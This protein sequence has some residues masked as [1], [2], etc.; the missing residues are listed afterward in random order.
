MMR[1]RSE[2]CAAMKCAYSLLFAIALL[3]ATVGMVFAGSNYAT[4]NP[5]GAG[6]ST[7]KSGLVIKPQSVMLAEQLLAPIKNGVSLPRDLGSADPELNEAIRSYQNGQGS[8]SPMT[9]QKVEAD[10]DCHELPYSKSLLHDFNDRVAEVCNLTPDMRATCYLLAGLEHLGYLPNGTVLNVDGQ[11]NVKF[12]CT[13]G[14]EY[15]FDKDGKLI[16]SGINEGTFNRSDSQKDIIGHIFNDMFAAVRALPRK[17][18]MTKDE[19]YDFLKEYIAKN[20][21]TIGEANDGH[22]DQVCRSDKPVS[23][24]DLKNMDLDDKNG[25]WCQ[26]DLPGCEE[27]VSEEGF[28]VSFVCLKCNKVNVSFAKKAIALEAKAKELGGDVKW[29]GPNAE[30]RAK[31]VAGNAK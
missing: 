24:E 16:A 10:S 30:Q 27:R 22:E 4:L 6:Q 3:S 7:V 12:V 29:F 21:I 9:K 28:F 13:N 5:A 15:V 2:R 14:E 26:C 20:T 25:D 23:V 17:S 31:S 8:E 11:H 18:S 1:N 19:F